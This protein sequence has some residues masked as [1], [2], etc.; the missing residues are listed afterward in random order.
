[1]LP[2]IL[3][4]FTLPLFIHLDGYTVGKSF[5][6]PRSIVAGPK[7]ISCLTNRGVSKFADEQNSMITRK[8]GNRTVSIFQLFDTLTIKNTNS[9]R[10]I[11]REKNKNIYNKQLGVKQT[12]I[13][14]YAGV[15]QA[16][17]ALAEQKAVSVQFDFVETKIGLDLYF[18]NGAERFF[19]G[20]AI[21]RKDTLQIDLV[22]FDQKILIY[23]KSDSSYAGFLRKNTRDGLKTNFTLF[24]SGERYSPI[25]DSTQLHILKKKY[26]IFFTNG[27]KTDT[28]VALFS[29]TGSILNATFQRVTGD[30]RYLTGRVDGRK[31]RLSS[32][33]GGNIS[34]Y[35]G[36]F[37]ENG[38]INGHMIGLKNTIEFSGKADDFAKLPD[39]YSLTQLKPSSEKLSFNFKN[40]NGELVSNQHVNF[41][42][43]PLVITIGGTWCPN[44]M[45]EAAFL[46]KWYEKNSSKGIEVV[47]LMFE[48]DTSATYVQKIFSDFSKRFNIK[49]PLLIG[50][51]A[52]KEIV[53]S[54]LPDLQTF[55]AFPTTLY[56]DKNGKVTSIHTGFNGPATG[57]NYTEWIRE[58]QEHVEQLLK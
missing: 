10:A 38:N 25:P 2:F 13:S 46:G 15:W 48:R 16:I 55:L 36:E 49:Y 21:Y 30:A 32:F 12:W 17:F 22:L 26:R 27:N 11:E 45:D 29:Q 57:S 4:I 6:E 54:K 19:G 51:L 24:K 28:A 14:R 37:H 34:A 47:G 50:G 3:F 5:K 41:V 31:F 8:Y 58:F 35:E 18:I 56:V 42:G 23:E 40:A 1:M 9:R 20:A 39:A 7:G 52:N 33:I 43:K 53:L 44:C